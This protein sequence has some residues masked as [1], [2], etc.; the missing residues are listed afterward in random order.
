MPVGAGA[1]PPKGKGCGG[2]IGL[3]IGVS[4]VVI[5]LL[6]VGV[7]GIGGLYLLGKSRSAAEAQMPEE[8]A[9]LSQP[10]TQQQAV[11]PLA[12]ASA[13][14]ATPIP[15][16]HNPAPTSSPA[17][18]TPIPMSAG[19]K[20]NDHFFSDDFETSYMNWDN[21]SDE[22]A[23]WGYQ[24]SGYLMRI[25][26]S[27]QPLSFE[28][29]ITSFSPTAYEFDAAVSGQPGEGGTGSFG[30][31]CD[32]KPADTS[33]Y[34]AVE[35]DPY[36]QVLLVTQ[37][38]NHQ[39]GASTGIL[40]LPGLRSNPGATNHFLVECQWKFV[41]VFVNGEWA[42]ELEIDSPMEGEMSLFIAN[43]GPISTEY[44]QVLVDNFS[45]WRPVQ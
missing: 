28:P 16:S 36:K 8:Q 38:N 5:G 17:L 11:Q 39:P 13:P 19:Q 24:N 21:G 23:D 32:Y 33:N 15:T 10:T 9:P 42:A 35:F 3:W 6:C 43:W 25:K 2:G 26:L 18:K 20:L 27:N 7:L 37:F 41:T 40:I 45:A 34:V 31:L 44:F 1:P 12:P 30:V 4:V 14:T 29:P 22:E